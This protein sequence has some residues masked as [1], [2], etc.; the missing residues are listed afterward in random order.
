[1]FSRKKNKT[2]KPNA[3]TP[4]APKSAAKKSG[5]GIPSIISSDLHVIGNI[6][7]GGIVDID[8]TIEGNVKCHTATLRKNGHIKGDVV[9]EMVHIYGTV[10][11]LIKARNVHFYKGCRAEGV[12]MHEALTIEDGAF[13]DGRFKRTEKLDLDDN[14]HDETPIDSAEKTPKIFS[15]SSKSF[16]DSQFQSP[17][18]M[19]E[20]ETD[21]EDDAQD[22]TA[23]DKKDKKAESALDNLRLISDVA[24]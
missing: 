8:G 4:E 10:Q 20:P 24:N 14:T 23:K 17:M 12:I 7:C 22:S 2:S 15:E 13:V 9:A 18:F 11:G 19:S 6:Q 16:D 5:T 1:M 3:A 21:S